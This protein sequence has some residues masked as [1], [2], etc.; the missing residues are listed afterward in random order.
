MP[1]GDFS[2]RPGLHKY[3]RCWMAASGGYFVDATWVRAGK[4]T[5]RAVGV[6][7]AMSDGHYFETV[8]SR[9]WRCDHGR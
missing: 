3:R 4:T 7:S 2:Y 5:L 8:D 9:I 1:L 6:F